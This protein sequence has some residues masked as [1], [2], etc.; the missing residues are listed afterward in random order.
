MKI[1]ATG[2]A[3]AT[4]RMK[5]KNPM[6]IKR[7]SV[8]LAHPAILRIFQELEAIEPERDLCVGVVK[9]RIDQWNAIFRLDRSAYAQHWFELFVYFPTDYP[10]RPPEIRFLN[11]P[12]HVNV[13]PDGE[14]STTALGTK[15]DWNWSFKEIIQQIKAVLMEPDTEVAASQQRVSQ[16]REDRAR[17]AQEAETALRND[18]VNI[19]RYKWRIR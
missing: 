14:V 2:V 8:N 5:L 11:P 6:K 12:Y 19:G 1:V 15:Y 9:G 3:M 7:N 4:R 18:R 13:S 10:Y 17:F 16:F